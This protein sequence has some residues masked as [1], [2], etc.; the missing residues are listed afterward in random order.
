MTQNVAA[1]AVAEAV[2]H[3]RAFAADFPTEDGGQRLQ[4]L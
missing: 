2:R 4:Q 1:A 3:L